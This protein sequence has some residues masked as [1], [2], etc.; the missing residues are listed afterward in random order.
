MS[1]FKLGLTLSG[2]RTHYPAR[3]DPKRNSKTQKRC[4]EFT[5]NQCPV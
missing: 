5:R 3:V 2:V 1:L 4:I